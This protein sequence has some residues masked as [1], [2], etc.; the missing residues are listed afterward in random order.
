MNHET[1]DMRLPDVDETELSESEIEVGIRIGVIAE[2]NAS[3]MRAH[4]T[5]ERLLQLFTYDSL[6]GAL[7][8]RG[9]GVEIVKTNN[10][11]YRWVHV[12]AHSILV[13]RAIWRMHTGEWPASMIDHVDGCKTNNAWEN[14]RLADHSLNAQNVFQ[15]MTTNKSGLRGVFVDPRRTARPFRS[16][17]ETNGIKR[18]LGSFET[19]EEAHAAY[20]AAKREDHQFSFATVVTRQRV[21]IINF[22]EDS[23]C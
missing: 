13:H 16:A 23:P 17:I 9:T 21:E 20:M 8:W 3:R 15:P 18:S 1:R 19:A 10:H 4:F 14:L 22:T 5:R 11:G 12:D 6:T 2:T 7:C